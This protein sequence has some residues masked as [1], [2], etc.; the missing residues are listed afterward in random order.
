ME[1]FWKWMEKKD[2]AHRGEDY[3]ALLADDI[4]VYDWTNQ[5]LVGYMIEYLRTLK[6]TTALL[7]HTVELT[8]V[9]KGDRIKDY[10]YDYLV[11][12]IKTGK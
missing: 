4:F 1:K 8:I 9:G 7:R 10:P 12:L 3:I 11:E 5:M 2:Y 6:S